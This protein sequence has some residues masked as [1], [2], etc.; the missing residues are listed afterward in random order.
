MKN[1]ILYLLLSI[2]FTLLSIFIPSIKLAAA[3]NSTSS[4]TTNDK[5]I[6][7]NGIKYYSG[8]VYDHKTNINLFDD[9]SKR[10]SFY[11]EDD[12]ASDNY[13]LNYYREGSPYLVYDNS[14]I[15]DLFGD[16]YIFNNSL[17]SNLFYKHE[18]VDYY[19]FKYYDSDFNNVLNL[20][21]MNNITFIKNIYFDENVKTITLYLKHDFLYEPL[22]Q[23]NNNFRDSF[24]F[25]IL[26]IDSKTYLGIRFNGLGNGFQVYTDG[27]VMDLAHNDNF[28]SLFKI[29]IPR[30]DYFK[31]ISI[32]NMFRYSIEDLDDNNLPW[33][34]A[35]GEETAFNEHKVIF[36]FDEKHYDERFSEYAFDIQSI[37][38]ESGE[39]ILKNISPIY[40]NNSNE[41]K[42]A[43][44]FILEDFSVDLVYSRKDYDDPEPYKLCSKY[45][46]QYK[47]FTCSTQTSTVNGIRISTTQ[48]TKNVILNF[49]N[50]KSI[51]NLSKGLY[52][53]YLKD[54]VLPIDFSDFT[55]IPNYLTF[56]TT[57]E[58]DSISNFKIWHY[59]QGNN[60][61]KYV[62]SIDKTMNTFYYNWSQTYEIYYPMDDSMSEVG[63]KYNIP[64]WLIP[65]FN[66][67]IQPKICMQ[68]YDFSFYFD[69]EKTLLIPN[70]QS[71]SFKLQF[72]YREPNKDSDD[73]FY[74]TEKG[75]KNLHTFTI[76]KDTQLILGDNKDNWYEPSWYDDVHTLKITSQKN[77]H[78]TSSGDLYSYEYRL[79]NIY[80]FFDFDD[81]SNFISQISPLEIYYITESLQT[82]KLV[83]N[84]LG[85]HTVYD[86]NGI[87]HVY[88]FSGKLM[89]E[90]GVYL[91]E[92]GYSFPAIDINKDGL[93]S[94]DEI[95]SPDTGENQIYEKY[96]E[97]GIKSLFDSFINSISNTFKDFSTAMKTLSLIFGG[98]ILLFIFTI[99]INILLMI[100]NL[101]NDTKKIFK[102]KKKR[103]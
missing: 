16:D 46:S 71:F 90:Y 75:R 70:V 66:K 24:T 45:S 2:T 36:G 10:A 78:Y 84:S 60:Y 11:Q 103:R 26:T 9:E 23:F 95:V 37:D 93:Y 73:G 87:P 89:N 7:E 88:D 38:L 52:Y 1:K 14:S 67:H 20:F 99:I 58:D 35:F 76:D 49:D 83:G 48:F 102:L 55:L 91:N 68:H 82:K 22:L 72:G 6:I 62:C 34:F 28:G 31:T 5:I 3:D 94:A 64:S 40:I 53:R 69:E 79:S 80:S 41:L 27:C 39:V 8:L 54:F 61:Q 50:S 15:I 43:K 29:T 4:S 57:F 59:Y 85:L 47:G 97:H 17:N 74:Y 13:Y 77:E 51:D 33:S 98:L 42:K 56:K 65:K 86:V 92:D 63:K 21:Y 96:D 30:V 100:K 32:S 18:N 81:V 25:P 19:G 44:S 12:N 101:F